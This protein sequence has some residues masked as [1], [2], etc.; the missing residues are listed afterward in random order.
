MGEMISVIVP[1]YNVAAYLG[2]CIDSILAQTY[3]E[4]EII[5]VDDGSTDGSGEICDEYAARD[6]RIRVIHQPNGGVSCARNAGLAACT[7]ELIGFVDADDRLHVSMIEKLARCLNENRADAAMCGFVDYP[8]GAPV[9]KG[10][11]SVPPCDFA[12]TVY[13]MMRRNGYFT[14]PWAKLFRRELVFREGRFQAFDPSLSFGEDEVWLLQVLR[15][16]KS[17]AFVP[18]ALYDW[19]PREGSITR[20]ETVTEK[21]LS[22]LNA[23]EKT[24][25]LLPD[26]TEIRSLARGRIYNDCFYLKVRAYSTGNKAA[27]RRIRHALRPMWRDFIR[28]PDVIPLRKCKLMFMEAEMRCG[29]P[30]KLV[31]KT[32]ALTH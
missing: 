11:F 7:G 27:L 3:R 30:G 26:D 14:S 12:G 9:K 1:V 2:E 32:E 22:L 4:L 10:L 19:L 28:S 20:Y 24:L 18:E 6:A 17:F 23:K 15:H 5:L 13:Q 29:L 25:A 31:R 16:G 8:H 21:Q